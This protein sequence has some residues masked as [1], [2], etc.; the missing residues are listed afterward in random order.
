[1]MTSLLLRKSNF[2]TQVPANT[3]LFEDFKRTYE[4]IADQN[5]G[6][7]SFI[8]RSARPECHQ[9]RAI[10]EN[11]YKNYPGQRRPKL[12]SR[13]Q[14]EFDSAFFELFLHELLLRNG[15]AVVVEPALT[16]TSSIPDFSARF[17]D[18]HEVIVEAA[19]ATDL[20]KKEK[21]RNARIE[22]LRREIDSKLPST[23]FW[24][25]LRQV[26]DED[27]VPSSKD[28]IRFIRARLLALTWESV[29]EELKQKPYAIPTWT[30]KNEAGF[31]VEISAF[32]K[33]A[34]MRRKSTVRTVGAVPGGV[35]WGG[36]GRA[37]RKAITDKCQKY[38]RLNIPFV[39]AVNALSN[40]GT[41]REDVEEALFSGTTQ[42]DKREAVWIG[43]QGPRNRGLSA[44]LIAKVW[45]W[46]IA[47]SELR[48]HHNPF[49][50]YP[51]ADLHWKIAQSVGEPPNVKS[52]DG[53]RP[54]ELFDLA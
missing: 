40:W 43:P 45:P 11:F 15:C 17:K 29:V 3:S 9:V 42:N 44:V 41:G 4:G 54:N 7:L 21:G 8:N 38:G 49:A 19:V 39:I 20:S 52:T 2:V 31:E 16:N 13:L 10:L 24:V 6:T 34:E 36:S 46:N 30:Y 14:K 53:I 50:R 33:A 47:S 12:K 35:R 23:D 37:L 5:E 22:T 28:I 25:S 51:C 1:M 26:S 27:L 18:G 32:P 48:L